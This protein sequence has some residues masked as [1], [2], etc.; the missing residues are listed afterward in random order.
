MALAHT[1]QTILNK[2]LHHVLST[3]GAHRESDL[4]CKVLYSLGRCD[5]SP[6]DLDNPNASLRT[7]DRTAALLASEDKEALWYDHGIIPDLQVCHLGID[8]LAPFSPT[9]RSHSQ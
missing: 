3:A 5:A 7:R 1:L 9:R 2:Q 8:F 4:M 6:D